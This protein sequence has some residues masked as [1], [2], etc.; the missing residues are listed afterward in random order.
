MSN[1]KGGFIGQD[2]LNAPDQATGVAGTAGDGQVSVA[3]TAPSDEG[4]SDITGFRA[5]VAGIG[6]SGTSS[7]LVVTGLTNGTAYTAN[8]WAI[9][10]FGTSAPSDASASF[11]PS[12]D[13]ILL[14][15]G[16]QT[17]SFTNVNI[18]EYIIPSTTGNP[19]DFGDL[20]STVYDAH[21]GAAGS[22][23]RTLLISGYNSAG[24]IINVIQYVNPASTGNAT[25]FGD[26]NLSSSYG[27]GATSNDTR[28]I[29]GESATV[30][31]SYVTIASTGNAANFGNSSEEMEGSSAFASS[32]RG[33]FVIG[34]GATN[35]PSN[36]LEY[37]TIGTTGNTTDFGNLTQS[38]INQT[39]GS[40]GTRGIIAGGS[41][42]GN[43][44]NIM[45]YVTTAS[46]GNA[47]D[48]GDLSVARQ[49]IA[50]AGGTTRSV[51][52]GGRTNSDP[53][54]INNI[55]YVT[56]ATAGNSVDFGDIS[57][58]RGQSTCGSADHGGLQ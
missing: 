50:G 15:G 41:G 2:G 22:K 25:D 48:F 35:N 27:S 16:R 53:Y 1:G 40:S 14:M 43:F 32:T 39:T 36:I 56:T 28:A 11:T 46:T 5:Q 33:V 34:K 26:T 4:T 47:S 9:N 42:G 20:L 31:I 7:P 12:L 38:R 8:V 54:F 21:D 52:F 6:T 3:F 18:I 55:E 17:N 57:V 49:S 30:R 37:V 58:I 44:Y 45:D 24:S 10:A 13:R 51:F 29:F 19:T 23:T